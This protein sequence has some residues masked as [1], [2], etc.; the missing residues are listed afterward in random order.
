MQYMFM[1]TQ[2]PTIKHFLVDL[3]KNEMKTISLNFVDNKI[4][5]DL[6]RDVETFSIST[7]IDETLLRRKTKS[8]HYKASFAVIYGNIS[9]N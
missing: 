4:R 9:V 8:R 5:V 6:F 3:E 7:L 1:P 2:N